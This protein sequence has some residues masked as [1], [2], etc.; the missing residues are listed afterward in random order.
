MKALWSLLRF[1]L[2]WSGALLAAAVFSIGTYHGWIRI[3]KAFALWLGFCRHPKDALVEPRTYT[4]R[5]ATCSVCPIFYKPLQTCGTPLRKTL[6][7]LGCWCFMPAK[8]RLAAAQCWI[9]ENA[10]D[11]AQYGWN[12]AYAR[13][14]ESRS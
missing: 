8:A 11:A 4:F 2:R 9:D 3:G 6:R 10:P 14:K 7:P 12:Q 5:L 13:Q 1:N